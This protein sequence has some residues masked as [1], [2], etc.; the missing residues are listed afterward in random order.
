VEIGKINLAKKFA[1]QV[2]IL[3]PFQIILV[4]EV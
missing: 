2:L 1:K 4:N 3:I